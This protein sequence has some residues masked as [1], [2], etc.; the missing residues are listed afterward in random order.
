MHDWKANLFLLGFGLFSGAILV[1]GRVDFLQRFTGKPFGSK[2]GLVSFRKGMRVSFARGSYRNGLEGE[3]CSP[4]G[5][6]NNMSKMVYF[7]AWMV[8]FDGI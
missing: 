5:S 3:Y 2:A 6:M 1:L 4:H 8:E 7:P